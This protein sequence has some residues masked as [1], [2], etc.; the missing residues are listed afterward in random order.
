MGTINSVVI[1]EHMK[2]YSQEIEGLSTLSQIREY[3]GEG[4]A[5]NYIDKKTKPYSYLEEIF[6]IDA[7]K[8]L[9]ANKCYRLAWEKDNKII[10]AYLWKQ[11][12][13]RLFV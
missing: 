9:R 4:F 1:P 13:I 5:F 11:L 3:Y 7:I 12:V 10:C 8:D 6:L 2:K